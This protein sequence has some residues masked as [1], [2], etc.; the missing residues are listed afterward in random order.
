MTSTKGVMM[1]TKT[2]IAG[3]SVV[4]KLAI[5][6]PNALPLKNWLLDLA[7]DLVWIPLKTERGVVKVMP[8]S[9]TVLPADLIKAICQKL[10]DGVIVQWQDVSYEV[11]GVETISGELFAFVISFTP[12]QKLP[13]TIGRATHSLFMQW[14]S[15]GDETLAEQVHQQAICPFTLT[16]LSWESKTIDLRITLLETK[17]LTPLLW[18]I[19]Q[20]LG[21]EFAITNIPCRMKSEVRFL[22][23][24]TYERLWLS[25]QA[26][27][28]ITLDFI[29]PT[30]FKQENYIQN[31]PLPELVF[32][33]LYRRWNA[34]AP[35]HKQLPSI[36][37]RGWVTAYELKTY[38]LK[39]QGGAEIGAQGWV[40]YQFPDIE[41]MKIATILAEF[42]TFAGVGRKTAMGMGRTQLLSDHRTPK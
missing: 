11:S 2:E 32:N 1:P 13:S 40:R 30:S 24:T 5:F 12:Y 15:K 41:Q 34:F 4:L 8:V 18:G 19:S 20:D 35:P 23:D 36:Q 31:F 16:T 17:L 28:S 27:S 42:A 10:A 6:D 26:Q 38:A 3:L 21:Q 33:S 37:W 7:P 9:T 39:M 29:T 22:E 14:L 25:G